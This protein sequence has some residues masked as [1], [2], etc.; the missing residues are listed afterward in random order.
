MIDKRR[1]KKSAGSSSSLLVQSGRL[2]Q[3]HSPTSPIINS[4]HI[5]CAE[6]SDSHIIFPRL[7]VHLGK[8]FSCATTDCLLGKSM[9]D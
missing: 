1:S 2:E 6:V 8:Q 5:L 4:F 7:L 3:E 9:N